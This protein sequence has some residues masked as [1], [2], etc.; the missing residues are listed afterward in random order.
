M[1]PS[2]PGEEPYSRRDALENHEMRHVW[3][4]A[5]WGPFFLSLPI[6]WLVH[7]GFSFSSLADS[8]NKIVRHISLGGLDSLFALVAWGIG[9]AKG[10]VEAA[11]HGGRR[12][13][14]AGAPVRRRRCRGERR[15]PHRGGQG[16]RAQ[17]V[18]RGRRRGR[19]D[20][21]AHDAVGAARRP[22]R[23]RRHGEGHDLALRAG[24]QDRQHV[25]QPQPREPVARPHPDHL[26]P[27]AVGGGQP[28]LVAAGPG[29]VRHHRHRRRR[30]P[31]PH[32]LRAGRGVPLGRPLHQHHDEQPVDRP[33]RSVQPGVRVRR[34]PQ[35]RRVGWHRRVGDRRPDR[36]EQRHRAALGRGAKRRGQRGGGDRHPAGVDRR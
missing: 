19:G 35:V 29:H 24:P 34:H 1:I 14:D 20:V 28:R 9:G 4:Y 27:G 3:Q 26:G 30:R 33:R 21:H 36:P 15:V 12:P 2:D 23:R 17:R 8:E 5:M 11:G 10:A 18:R 31:V 25:V 22:L 13:H 16:G 32:A 7:V 6:P